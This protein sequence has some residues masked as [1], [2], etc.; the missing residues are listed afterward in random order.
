MFSSIRTKIRLVS[1][2]FIWV[3]GALLMALTVL[4]GVP[5]C[6]SGGPSSGPVTNPDEGTESIAEQGSV[7]DTEL[8]DPPSDLPDPPMEA[9]EE[10]E[11]VKEEPDSETT[12]VTDSDSETDQ[13]TVT[14][15]GEETDAT[16]VA[17]QEELTSAVEQAESE[18]ENSE[19]IVADGGTRDLEWGHWRGPLQTGVSLDQGLPESWSQDGDN[20][21]WSQPFG[22]RSCPVVV[23]GRVCIIGVVGDDNISTQERVVCFDAENGQK[24]WEHRFNVFHSTIVANRVGWA[25]L[26]GD[27]ETGY[28]YAHGVQDLLICFDPEGR[29]VWSHSMKEKFGSVT[30]YGGRIHT[31]VIDED[32]LIISFLSSSWGKQGRPL[33]RYLALD[34]TT[35]EVLWWAAPGGRPLDTTYSTPVF[36]IIGGQRLMIAGNADGNVYAMKARTGEMV[37][38]F[39]FSK[40]G[41]NSSVVVSGDH[42]FACHGEENLDTSIMGRLVCIDATGKGDITETHELW[43]YD[44]IE[45]GYCSPALQEGK[46]YLADNAANLYCLDSTAGTLLWTHKLGTVGRG[47]TP[48]LADDKIYVTEYQSFHILRPGATEC[49]TLDSELFNSGAGTVEIWGAPAVANGRVYFTTSDTIYAIGLKDWSG[50]R[51][52]QPATVSESVDEKGPLDHVQVVPAETLLQPGESSQFRVHGYDSAGRFLGVQTAAFVATGV[53]GQVNE[54]GAFQAATDNQGSAGEVT[55]SVG[56]LTTSARIRILPQLPFDENFDRYEAGSLPSHWLS[57]RAKYVVH[58]LDGNKVLRKT[59]VNPAVPV[60]R[61]VAF[62]GPPEWANYTIEADCMGTEASFQLPDMGLVNSRYTM[63]MLGNNGQVAITTWDAVPRLEET[64]DYVVDPDVW[65]RIKLRV[66]IESGQALIRGKVWLREEE[67][68]SEWTIEASDP[69]PNE[70]GS[71]ALYAYSTAILEGSPGTEVFFDNVSIV[72]NQ[73]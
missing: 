59:N 64:V 63:R 49:V 3:M 57:S 65:Y 15:P 48:V 54:Q 61:A 62:F 39:R 21:V 24:L 37:W 51:T 50:K 66:D 67:E 28:V 72:S 31:P 11:D 6:G 35:G 16:G 10:D 18:A 14:S 69:H 17:D 25:N 20:L 23:D 45:A 26:A 73:P 12:V 40:R 27:P 47:S 36:A 53:K 71:P 43:R 60:A 70:N 9:V 5:G 42:V 34:K 1:P 32:R 2:S 8:P 68:P 4:A 22:G 55:A 46:V 7:E 38:K 29:I 30:G 41:I 52:E 19:N 56:E 58:D 44:G 13:D 33:H